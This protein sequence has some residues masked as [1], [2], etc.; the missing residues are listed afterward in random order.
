MVI[1]SLLF[2]LLAYGVAIIIA[3]CVALIIKFI[4][5]IVQRGGKRADAGSAKQES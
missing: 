5:L 2:A 3:I 4:G 1:N